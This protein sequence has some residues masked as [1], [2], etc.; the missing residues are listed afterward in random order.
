M[1]PPG[2]V[3]GAVGGFTDWT[4]E[5][6][7]EW[8]AKE[9]GG[10]VSSTRHAGWVLLKG[11]EMW[12]HSGQQQAAPE[13]ICSSHGGQGLVTSVWTCAFSLKSVFILDG[14]GRLCK[15]TLM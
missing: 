9:K 10:L 4:L 7:L 5:I 12:Q 15:A 6:I 11:S 3:S 8:G 13:G 2:V 1:A 14:K